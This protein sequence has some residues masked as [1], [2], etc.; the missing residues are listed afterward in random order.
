ME[1]TIRTKENWGGGRAELRSQLY[2]EALPW[3]RSWQKNEDGTVE[4]GAAWG[5]GLR[6]ERASA[7]EAGGN[8]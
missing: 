3:E 1:I 2:P 6:R 4:E 7:S 8:R 5:R